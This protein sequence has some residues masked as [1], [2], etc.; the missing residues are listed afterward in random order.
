MFHRPPKSV[1]KASDAANFDTSDDPYT[2]LTSATFPSRKTELWLLDLDSGDTIKLAAPHTYYS[3]K[4]NESQNNEVLKKLAR[5]QHA[6]RAAILSF[7]NSRNEAEHPHFTWQLCLISL[8]RRMPTLA[9]FGH[10]RGSCMIRLLIRQEQLAQAT[11]QY[12]SPG[13]L[14][15]SQQDLGK[16]LSKA[17]N[18]SVYSS[19]SQQ[20]TQ[21]AEGDRAQSMPV[22]FGVHCHLLSHLTCARPIAK[23][24]L[25]QTSW[26]LAPLTSSRS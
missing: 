1:A 5:M 9:I 21:S 18:R 12:Q 10:H 16:T 22:S 15:H 17:Q 4:I 14:K 23:S 24:D 6:W 25:I 3:L 11:G 7:M 8:P 26:T 2:S 20:L 19:L 13:L